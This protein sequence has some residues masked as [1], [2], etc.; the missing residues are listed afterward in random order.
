MRKCRC[1]NGKFSTKCC[2]SKGGRK[3]PVTTPGSYRPQHNT[4]GDLMN[5]GSA[6]TGKRISNAGQQVINLGIA[7]IVVAQT[8]QPSSSGKIWMNMTR[9]DARIH[10]PQIKKADMKNYDWRPKGTSLRGSIRDANIGQRGRKRSKLRG[11]V[12]EHW[13]RQP[14]DGTKYSQPS[15][16]EVQSHRRSMTRRGVGKITVGGSMRLLGEGFMI[17][18]LGQY[19]SWLYQDPSLNTMGKIGQDILGIPLFEPLAV[20]YSNKFRHHDFTLTLGPIS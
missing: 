20:G 14:R 5:A 12:E 10:A 9:K 16:A 2:T 17:V 4:I 13:H 8:S 7:E 19:A 15:K 3:K 11:E 1:P 18:Q 6:L